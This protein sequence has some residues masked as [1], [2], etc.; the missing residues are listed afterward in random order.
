M[1]TPFHH[2]H[3]LH[4]YWL[5]TVVFIAVFSIFGRRVQLYLAELFDQRWIA[6]G[7]F[8]LLLTLL[9]KLCLKK[10]KSKRTVMV[11][12][13]AFILL[14]AGLAAMCGGILQP[15]ESFHFLLFSWFG[16]ISAGTFGLA[17]GMVAVFII[18]C[19]DEVLQYFLPDRVGDIHD[20]VINTVSGGLGLLARGK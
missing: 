5:L 4:L 3:R 10:N 12:F 20:I 7:I 15:V 1:K 13:A 17:N 14:V 11:V 6:G 16:W 8:L 2:K 9:A 19:S 18:S